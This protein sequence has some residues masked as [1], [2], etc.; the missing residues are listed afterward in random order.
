MWSSLDGLLSQTTL[1]FRQAVPVSSVYREIFE[2]LQTTFNF[3]LDTIQ[4]FGYICNKNRHQTFFRSWEPE[5]C[6]LLDPWNR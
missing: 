5:K 2:Y 1:S 3:E 4:L 6:D